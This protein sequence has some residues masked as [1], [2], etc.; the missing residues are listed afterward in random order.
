MAILPPPVANP[1]YSILCGQSQNRA[2][3]HFIDAM[4]P[5]DF[6]LCIGIIPLHTTAKKFF[7]AIKTRLCP[8]NHFQKLKVVRN[9]VNLPVENGSGAPKSKTQLILLLS[10]TFVLFKQLKVGADELKGLIAQATCHAPPTLYQLVTAAILAKNEDKPSSTFVGQVILNRSSKAEYFARSLSSFVYRMA[11]SAQIS[12]SPTTAAPSSS[13]TKGFAN[14]NPCLRLPSP[15]TPARVRAAEPRSPLASNPRFHQEGVS[16][17]QFLEHHAS[18]KV[19]IDSSASVHLSGSSRFASDLRSIDPFKTFSSNSK[20]FITVTQTVTLKLPVYGGYVVIRDIA[21][22]GQISGTILSVGQLYKAGIMPFFSMLSLSLLVCNR[23]VH[24]TFL[25]NCWC[26]NIVSD[27]GTNGSSAVSPSPCLIEMNPISQPTSM[28]LS[29]CN[30][31][32]RLGHA[33]DKVILSFLH[34]HVPTFATKLWCAFF[35][36]VC[37]KAKSM[38]LRDH[39]LTYSFFFPLKSRSKAPDAI[40]ETINLLRVQLRVTP[41]AVRTDNAREF[42]SVSFTGALRKMGVLFVPSL[43]YSPQENGEEEQLNKTLSNMARAMLVEGDMPP[44]FWQYAYVNAGFIHNHLP[45]SRCPESS[46]YKELYGRRPSV[47]AIYPFGAEAIVHVPA[48]QKSHK[49]YP[50]G[51]SCNLLRPIDGSGGWLLWDAAKNC[52]IQSASVVFPAFQRADIP[53]M[54][55]HKGSLQHVLNSMSVGEVLTES[56]FVEE[57]AA[58]DSLPLPKDVSIPQ[59]LGQIDPTGVRRAWLN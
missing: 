55:E 2:I 37:A 5:H 12:S 8:G 21:F 48:P 9:I 35:C 56:I 39:A 13:M 50:R 57:M 25:N 29:S 11:D 14:L 49:L 17:V 44:R 53:S 41:K 10:R 38:H 58:I 16:Q 33:S 7:E 19:L 47:A 20:S 36:E 42:T 15:F 26:M 31:H 6:V 18:D 24:T 3:S 4:V 28:V 27:E 1:R 22:S 23:L 54:V 45:N 52:L 59:H 43:P 51:I 30:W 34:Q 32:M 46:P 40:L